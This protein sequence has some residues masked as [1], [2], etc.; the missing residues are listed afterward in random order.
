M[1]SAWEWVSSSFFYGR[2]CG[3]AVL[4]MGWLSKIRDGFNRLGMLWAMEMV[5]M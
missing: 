5:P 2:R 3:S 1:E 4:A